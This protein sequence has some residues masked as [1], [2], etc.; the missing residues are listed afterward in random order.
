MKK[1]IVLA[2]VMIG[3]YASAM[4][5]NQKYAAKYVI[6][7]IAGIDQSGTPVCVAH[8]GDSFQILQDG[9]QIRNAQTG[10]T[11]VIKGSSFLYNY[12]PADVPPCTVFRFGI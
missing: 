8:Y 9:F 6:Y 4:A 5:D 1:I 2:I 10:H 12:H 3:F 7:Q 11:S